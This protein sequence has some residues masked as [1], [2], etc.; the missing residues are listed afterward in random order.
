MKRHQELRN[1]KTIGHEFCCEELL[2]SNISQNTIVKL[3]YIL[4][5]DIIRGTFIFDYF[6]NNSNLKPAVLDGGNE[7]ILAKWP[8]EKHIE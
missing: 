2:Q 7:I 5:S 6:Y 1:C 4:S 3:Q 8:S